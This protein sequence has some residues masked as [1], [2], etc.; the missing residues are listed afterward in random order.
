[1][2]YELRDRLKEKG[3][4]GEAD[5]MCHGLGEIYIKG[6]ERDR[7]AQRGGRD[8]HRETNRDREIGG[9]RE[10]EKERVREADRQGPEDM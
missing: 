8:R 10:I 9:D 7:G 4:R 1:M 5:R 6:T 3:G 2:R